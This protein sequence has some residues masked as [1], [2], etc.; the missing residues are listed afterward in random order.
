MITNIKSPP[1]LII[2]M[3]ILPLFALMGM[4]LPA[5]L[6]SQPVE[7]P[8][9]STQTV[10]KLQGAIANLASIQQ[11]IDTKRKMISELKNQL[12]RLKDTSERQDVEQQIERY[13]SE[14][15]GLEL[16]LEQVVL[17][18]IDLS[19]F[20]AAPDMKMD[21]R[22]EL[23][24]IISPLLTILKELTAK[25]RQI[26]SLR[27][28]I[29]QREDQLAMIAK[30][31]DSIRSFMQENL[32]ETTTDS[33]NR[34]LIAWEQRREDTQ[35]E[36]EITRFRL[37]SL[38]AE[39]EPWQA[40]AS[41]AFRDFLKG[42]GL[43]L[44]LAVVSSFIVWLVARGFLALYLRWLYR[45]R[46]DIG[47]T[48]APLVLY[49]YRLATAIFIVLAIIF[50]LYIRGDVLLLTLAM[51]ALA[52]VAL[53]LRQTLP[54]YTAELRLLL[55]V[56]PVR[57]QERL[58][59]DGIPY[60]VES[61]SIYTVLRN[62][63]LEG[64]VRLPL[65]DMN[66]QVSRPAASEPWFPCEPGDYLLLADGSYGK[67]LR[68]TIEMLEVA[69]RD[70]HVQISTK[71]FLNQNH[72]NLSRDGFGIGCTFGIDYQHQTICLDVVPRRLR[73]AIIAR[74]SEAGLGQS[75]TEII[76]DFKEAGASSLDYQI[77]IILNGEAAKA[78]FKAQRLVQQ[79][80]VDC[81]NREGW[82]IPFT[83]VTIHASHDAG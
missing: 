57:E 69:V 35:R 55:G 2:A 70:T 76:V 17:S 4:L 46:S 31:L 5:E 45:T 13:K 22:A 58:V 64:V 53:S 52:G 62:P 41:A 74:F 30:A 66:E 23:E 73:E 20:V 63:S 25:P 75:I 43:T 38:E 34:L 1:S 36:L 29:E 80:C 47:V 67:V 65:H 18:G 51:I 19:V 78:F 77:Y 81:C 54:R 11:A 10:I 33:L 6:K 16:S 7:A 28:T 32:T 82:V 14:I 44:L 3:I 9:Q 60:N 49:S 83:Q 48:R 71:E 50:V 37:S 68:Q 27:R 72:R 15:N 56:G 26:D 24:E 8:E 21:W 39:R 40:T 12:K 79:A 42:R 61:L 59:L